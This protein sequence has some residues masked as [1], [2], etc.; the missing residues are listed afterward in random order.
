MQRAPEH[1]AAEVC[2][3]CVH[4]LSEPAALETIYPGLTA[5]GS[6]YASVRAQDGLCQKHDIY[7][8]SEDRCASFLAV[9]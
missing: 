1:T 5:M 6:G 4:F 3:R 8:P 7:L 2:A 9:D